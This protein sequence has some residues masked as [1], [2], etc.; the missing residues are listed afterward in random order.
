IIDDKVR[1]ILREIVVFGFLDRPQLDPSIPVNDPRSKQAAIDV[2]R[3]GIVLLKNDSKILPLDK[4]NTRRIAV[5]GVNAQGEPPT[6]A[7]SAEV[8]AS[9]DFTSEID[10]I[11]AQVPNAAVDYISALVP[12]PA[13]AAWQT[14]TGTAGL[15][16]QYFNSSDLSGSPVATRI[17]TELNFTS[18]NSGNV[19]VANPSSFSGIWTGKVQPTITGYQV[20]KVTSV[21]PAGAGT[22]GANVRL[23]V[24]NQLIIDDFSPTAM[25]DTP[26]SAT[27]PILPISGKIFLQAGAAYDLRLEAKNL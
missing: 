8:E 26:I 2:A 1:R 4:N 16:G 5:I 9:S 14:G 7:G 12:D 23:Y 18:F 25:P 19:P 27:P 17:D 22:A 13:T 6:T 3:E 20:F 21:G 24:N 11:K 10:G 15:I